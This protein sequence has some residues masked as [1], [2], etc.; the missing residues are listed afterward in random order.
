MEKLSFSKQYDNLIVYKRFNRVFFCRVTLF[1][2]PV[3]HSLIEKIMFN[4][5]SLLKEFEKADTNK[6]G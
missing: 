2:D 3:Y 5:T 6:T 4:R 1:E